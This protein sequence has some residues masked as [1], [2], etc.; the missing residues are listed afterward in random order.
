MKQDIQGNHLPVSGYMV[1]NLP[2]DTTALT[3]YTRTFADHLSLDVQILFYGQILFVLL[4]NVV[5]WGSHNNL[6]AL[7]G[8]LR[9]QLQA[10]PTM[11]RHGIVQLEPVPDTHLLSSYSRFL[12]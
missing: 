8:D 3:R 1:S 10:I 12:L 11:E 7:I 2:T 5:W 6:H 4:A 9:E